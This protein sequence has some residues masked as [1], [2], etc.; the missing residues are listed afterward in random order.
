M[1]LTP[2]D[3]SALNEAFRL[4][5]YECPLLNPTILL[6]FHLLLKRGIGYYL[7]THKYNPRCYEIWKKTMVITFYR[8]NGLYSVHIHISQ[9]KSG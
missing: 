9:H 6:T 5:F 8:V 2:V 4:I 3:F 7:G 1:S